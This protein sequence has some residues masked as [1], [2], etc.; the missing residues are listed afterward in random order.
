M[1]QS[2]RRMFRDAIRATLRTP[3]LTLFYFHTFFRQSRAVR[4]R[5]SWERRGV[6][7]P[8]FLI[9]S[10]TRRCNL[11]C[12][13]CYARSL[14]ETQGV[15]LSLPRIES[16]FREARELGI[17]VILLAGGEP[18]ARPEILDLAA[19]FPEII[20]PVFTNGLMFDTVLVQKFR[21]NKNLIPVISLEGLAEAT[22]ERRGPGVYHRVETLI[23]DLKRW[24]VFF[25]LSLTVTRANFATVTSESFV[26]RMAGSGVKLFFYVEYI[27]VQAGT[28]ALVPTPAQR[29]QLLQSVKTFRA[30]HAGLFIAFPGDEEELG[31]CLASGRGFLHVSPEGD[32]EPC[33]FAPYSDTSLRDRSLREALQS[34]LLRTIRAHHGELNETRGG[35]ALWEKRDWVRS[36]LPV[37]PER[38]GDPEV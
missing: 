28:E 15:E 35:C 37:A 2:M 14:R 5:R 20:F 10:I 21:K 13:G 7:V 23:A 31:G 32:I 36:L 3:S 4:L 27:P 34:R 30:R 9:V 22:D 8:P 6:H 33:P 11:S 19:G 17:S 26:R 24:N 25:G 16:L 12:Q 1:N 29:T 38:P 18:L